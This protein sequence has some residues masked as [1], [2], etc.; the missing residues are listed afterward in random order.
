MS[1]CLSDR[2]HNKTKVAETKI[3]KLGTQIVLHDTSPTNE[4]YVKGQRL[5]LGLGLGLS[6]SSLSS[7]SLVLYVNIL[8]KYLIKSCKLKLELLVQQFNNN[9][10]NIHHFIVP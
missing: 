9:K 7:A 1:V 10:N 4:Y 3:A 5:M 6:Y 8:S 2:L